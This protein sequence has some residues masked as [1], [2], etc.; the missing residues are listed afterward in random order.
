MFASERGVRFPSTNP[1]ASRWAAPQPT[2]KGAALFNYKLV[3]EDGTPADPP[4]FTTAVP[5]WQAGDAIRSAPDAHCASSRF[6]KASSWSNRCPR[7]TSS[8]DHVSARSQ[9]TQTTKR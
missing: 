1:I 9:R 8:Q 3:L 2:G 6:G 4:T 5:D 7:R